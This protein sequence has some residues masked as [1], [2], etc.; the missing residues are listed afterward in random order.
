MLL[1]HVLLLARIIAGLAEVGAELAGLHAQMCDG[2]N[3][4]EEELAQKLGTVGEKYNVWH[5]RAMS[6][7]REDKRM[8]SQAARTS[9]TG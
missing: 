2:N 8:K 3:E 1:L 6:R 4:M 9:C 5:Q 7:I